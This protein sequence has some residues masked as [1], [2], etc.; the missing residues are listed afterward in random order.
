M[1]A[2]DQKKLPNRRAKKLKIIGVVILILGIAS[3]GI[4]YW[5]ETRAPDL[6][7]DPAMLGF[8]RSQTR[9]MEM[10][11][12][13]EGQLIEDWSNDLKQPGTQAVI[14]II[15]S[16]IIASGFFYFA[17]LPGDDAQAN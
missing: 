2:G 10:L 12:G 16:A 15:F 13:K 4:L 3:A 5:L 6:S 11:Y 14:I 9:Q 1:I 7:D 17:R 8:D